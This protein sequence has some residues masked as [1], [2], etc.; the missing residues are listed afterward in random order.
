V[1]PYLN[2]AD[3]WGRFKNGRGAEAEQIIKA[4]GYYDLV[5]NNDFSP[6]EF[7]NGETGQNLGAAIQG[8]DA[9]CFSAIYFGGLGLDRVGPD[10]IVVNPRLTSDRDF[11]TELRVPGGVFTLSR[12]AGDLSVRRKA[13]RGPDIHLKAP[14]LA[15]HKER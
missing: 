12:T 5:H 1:W 15:L 11:E 4:V 7:L 13:G 14:Q 2:C 8:W 3:A 10:S 9:D 6:S